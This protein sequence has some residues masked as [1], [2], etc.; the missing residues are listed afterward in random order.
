M[1]EHQV[2]S[3][4][5]AQLSLAQNIDDTI[6]TPEQEG[7]KFL[8]FSVNG[9]IY[10]CEIEKIKEIIEYG[11]VTRVPLTPQYLR[12]V[13]NLRG[14]VVPVVD[15]ATRLG[16]ATNP[17]SKRTCIIIIEMN[18]IDDEIVDIS[19]VVDEV[20]EVVSFSDEQIIAA[21]Q[22]GTDIRADFI[23]GM[24]KLNGEFIILLD[25]EEV[26]SVIE[27]SAL[28]DLESNGK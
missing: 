18:S 26:L 8:T 10:G 4:E 11:S 24:G 21:P 1:N 14:S 27:L 6:E 28:V 16:K 25:L 17:V 12:G 2:L 9:G 3:N 22:F 15:L 20:D 13:I 7:L 5:Q 23:S 19:F